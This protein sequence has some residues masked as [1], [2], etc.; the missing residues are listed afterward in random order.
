[1]VQ[2]ER[3]SNLDLKSVPLFVV[4][5]DIRKRVRRQALIRSQAVKLHI[6]IERFD[7]Q[8]EVL[9]VICFVLDRI[10][11]EQSTGPAV[12]HVMTASK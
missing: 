11:I 5:N 4:N 2:G 9:I 7:S 1:M 6:A 12:D 8:I 3:S 10:K